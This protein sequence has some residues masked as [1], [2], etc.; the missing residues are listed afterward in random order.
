MLNF[1]CCE[2]AEHEILFI[3]PAGQQ[4]QPGPV[5]GKSVYIL[6]MPDLLRCSMWILNEE[7][8]LWMIFFLQ[9]C[10]RYEV[11]KK[12][13]RGCDGRIWKGLSI[14]CH[15]FDELWAESF[16]VFIRLLPL[17]NGVVVFLWNIIRD[18]RQRLTVH[19]E[20]LP[21]ENWDYVLRVMNIP[22]GEH[23]RWD[24]VLIHR[25]Y[26][27]QESIAFL[28]HWLCCWWV[29]ILLHGW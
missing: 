7:V 27:W 21:E 29:L 11:W 19:G 22:A 5:Y 15:S 18:S 24:V 16:A 6:T 4:G 1:V 23:I 8:M 9:M 17:K 20:Y 3:F 10:S 28:R 14:V 2:Y 26:M 13:R 25:A 12:Q